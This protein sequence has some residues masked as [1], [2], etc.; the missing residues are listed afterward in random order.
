MAYNLHFMSINYYDKEDF[1]KETRVVE[2]YYRPRGY[3]IFEKKGL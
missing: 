2:Y 1:I 3:R